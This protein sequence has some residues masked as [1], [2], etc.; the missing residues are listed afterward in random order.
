MYDAAHVMC[1]YLKFPLMRSIKIKKKEKVVATL[2][3]VLGPLLVLQ[4]RLC[5]VVIVPDY[6]TG[7]GTGTGTLSLPSI[8]PPCHARARA[9]A[10]A[11]TATEAEARGG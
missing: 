2:L 6:C 5:P 8:A 9:R 1:L 7:T 10:R 11:R 3:L 4:V